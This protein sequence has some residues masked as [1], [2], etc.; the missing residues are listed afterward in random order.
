MQVLLYWN[1]LLIGSQECR[2]LV[3]DQLLL[4]IMCLNI[5][6]TEAI[7][8]E[9]VYN[10]KKGVSWFQNISVSDNLHFINLSLAYKHLRLILY[11]NSWS[12]VLSNVSKGIEYTIIQSSCDIVFP[13]FCCNFSCDYYDV[14]FLCSNTFSENNW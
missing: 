8:D 4:H 3:L 12:F 13:N 9:H 2:F 10:N 14:F 5:V 1:D 11:W 6:Q 7:G